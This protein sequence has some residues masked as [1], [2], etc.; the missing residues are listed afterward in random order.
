MDEMERAGRV[1]RAEEIL[2]HSFADKS[3]IEAAI[4]H[5]S[6]LDNGDRVSLGYE[7]LEFLGDSIVGSI[8]AREVFDR[9]PEMNEGGM[10]RIKVSVVAGSTLSDVSAELGVADCIIFGG[11]EV[12]TGRRGLHS[13]LENVY[14]SMVAALYLDAGPEVA[15]AWVLSTLGDRILEESAAE[16]ESPKSTLQEIL[17]EHRITPTYRIVEEVGPPHDRTFTAVVLSGD[18]PVGRGC[19][20]SKK[21]AESAAALDAMRRMTDGERHPL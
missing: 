16:P 2:G 18:D 15:R 4:T 10:T 9:F 6:A 14:E 19:G 8:I 1:R 11:S 21:E 12:G 17:Q 5:P 7:R 13:A 3:L 20:R